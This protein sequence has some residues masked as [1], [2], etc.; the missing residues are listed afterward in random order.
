[1]ANF[2]FE[3]IKE[4]LDE[5]LDNVVKYFSNLSTME[6]VGWGLVILGLILLI[7]GLFLL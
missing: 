6:T 1:M 3:S 7:V 4:S 2:D 5:F